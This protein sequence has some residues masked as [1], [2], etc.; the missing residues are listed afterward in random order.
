MGRPFHISQNLADK[1]LRESAV[2]PPPTPHKLIPLKIQCPCGQK[3]AFDIIPLNDRMPHAV[4]CPACGA[5]GTEHANAS[6]AQKLAEITAAPA[7]K[8]QGM[9]AAASSK[10]PPPRPA[11]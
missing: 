8:I 1:P 11:A 5:D 3:F 2:S 6:L 9:P 4:A 10:G 7:I